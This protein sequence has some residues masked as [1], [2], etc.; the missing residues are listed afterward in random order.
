[1]DIKSYIADRWVSWI[2]EIVVLSVI[3]FFTVAETQK[4]NE[5]TREIM[6][7]YDQKFSEYVAARSE[8][9]DFVSSEVKGKVE[10]VTLDDVKSV[11]SE[12][13]HDGE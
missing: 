7:K 5:L 4:T 12:M 8:K 1:M 9:L 11:L 10:S 6:T 3:A 13:A 2:L